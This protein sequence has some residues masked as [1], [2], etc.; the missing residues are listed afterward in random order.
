MVQHLGHLDQFYFG[1]Q[2]L[3]AHFDVA[4]EGV[5]CRRCHL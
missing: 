2:V 4:I 1:D 3:I 5:N